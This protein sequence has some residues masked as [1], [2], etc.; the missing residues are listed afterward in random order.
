MKQII[1]TFTIAL[2]LFIHK[3][4]AQNGLFFYPGDSSSSDSSIREFVKVRA[5]ADG[6]ILHAGQA[7][8]GSNADF[9]LCKISASGEILWQ[10]KTGTPGLDV[11]KNFIITEDGGFVLVGWSLSASAVY[12]DALIIRLDAN[13]ETQWVRTFG[14]SDDDEAFGATQLSDGNLLISGTTYSF[15]PKLRNAFAAKMDLNSGDILWSNAYAKGNFNYFI[16]AIA[17]PGAGAI[18]C[19]YTWVTTGNSLFDPFFVRLDSLGNPVW[20]KWLKTAGSQII[21]DFEKDTDGGVVFAG[22][23]TLSGA[24]NQNYIAKVNASGEHQWSRVFGTPN[25]DRIWDL[26]VLPEGK[27]LVAGFSAKNGSDT[28]PRNGFVARL[29]SDG[30]AE[31]ALLIGADDTITTTFTGITASGNHMEA[32]GF[33]YRNHPTGAGVVLKLPILDFSFTCDAVAPVSMPGTALTAVDSSG[34]LFSDGGVANE[35][36]A[37]SGNNNLLKQPLCLLAAT[38]MPVAEP[39]I[40]LWPNPG[41]GFYRIEN[42]PE[43]RQNLVRVYSSAGLLCHSGILS[44]AELDL[45]HLPNGLYHIVLGNS[46]P[47]KTIRISKISE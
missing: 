43:G 37:S 20:S 14:G 45:R 6:S 31:E 32:N 23:S 33:S 1:Y 11:L 19:G 28:S 17:L 29:S 27:Y 25:S 22:V 16:D 46:G 21:Y 38:S 36:S 9:S 34:I 5:L 7:D 30:Q 40:S 12:S 39:G 41:F 13:G 2:L 15:G 4:E 3:V 35:V 47:G 24:Q 42:L 18:A 44:G 8:E 10:K 26:C